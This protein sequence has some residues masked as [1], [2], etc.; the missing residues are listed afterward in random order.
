MPNT[1]AA[2]K[3]WR[4]TKKRTLLN[5]MAKAK[6]EIAIKFARKAMADKASDAKVKVQTAIKTLDRTAQ[7]G[8]IKPG[9]ADRKK[10]RLMKALN[11]LKK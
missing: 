4:Q 2:A 3:A 6:L 1:K 8:I 10:S 9:N 7:K 11:A 5:T